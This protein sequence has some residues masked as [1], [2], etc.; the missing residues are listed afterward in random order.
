MRI[1]AAIGNLIALILAVL[2]LTAISLVVIYSA[3]TAVG[4]PGRT[5][6]L[7][8]NAADCI[9]QRIG[10]SIIIVSIDYRAWARWSKLIYIATMALLGSVLLGPAIFGSQRCGVGPM[11]L[12][13]SEL[14]KIAIVLVWPN[15][16]K[17]ENAQSLQGLPKPWFWC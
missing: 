16:D 6:A 17:E 9:R 12:Q 7:C 2:A 11:S 14:A 15:F 8:P 3:S 1:P 13:P 5:L 10:A 4:C